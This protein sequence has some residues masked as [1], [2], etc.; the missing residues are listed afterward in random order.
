MSL[1]LPQ[2]D[3]LPVDWLPFII[4]SLCDKRDQMFWEGL[5]QKE[6]FFS[7]SPLFF[8]PVSTL[9]FLLNS[10][11]WIAPL[12]YRGIMGRG[13]FPTCQQPRR[14]GHCE[15]F[16][17]QCLKQPPSHLLHMKEILR[18]SVS[19]LFVEWISRLWPAIISNDICHYNKERSF[20]GYP[21]VVAGSSSTQQESSYWHIR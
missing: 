21:Y 10:L 4:K 12:S 14:P 17:S 20:V 18:P 6:N 7:S 2:W 11:E 5:A 15:C 19:P 3:D 9:P 1:D 13:P 8:V 16:C